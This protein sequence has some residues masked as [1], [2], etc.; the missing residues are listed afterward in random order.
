[1][2]D[3][4]AINAV[5]SE[6]REG[7]SSSDAERV[8]RGYATEFSDW[9]FGLPAIGRGES[10]TVLRVRL[11]QMFAHNTVQLVPTIIGVY[12]T[13]STAVARGW[14]LLTLTAH[15]DG[16][17]RSLRTRF[18]ELWRKDPVEGWQILV[19]IDNQDGQS[20]MPGML[21]DKLHAGHFDEATRRL[22][23]G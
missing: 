2:D 1:M 13:G 5:K 14:H 20:M 23:E 22:A 11:Q 17:K 19:S 21:L 4:Y 9:G 10:K 8:L 12:I 3:L 18:L 6:I 15:K 7:Y 16:A